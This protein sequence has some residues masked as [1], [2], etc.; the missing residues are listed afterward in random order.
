MIN[1]PLLPDPSDMIL[2]WEYF[3]NCKNPGN[4]DDYGFQHSGQ[5]LKKRELTHSL[6][7]R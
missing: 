2:S 5:V 6:Q 1:F 4:V 3:A 7:Q